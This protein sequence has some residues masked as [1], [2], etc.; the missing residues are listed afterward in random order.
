LI[1]D[2]RL[3][4]SVFTSWAETDTHKNSKAIG[5]N[6]NTFRIQYF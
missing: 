1:F 5:V 6:K 3:R 2:T 4:E